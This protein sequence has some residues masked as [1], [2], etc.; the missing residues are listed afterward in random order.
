M[1]VCAAFFVCGPKND[2]DIHQHY[3]GFDELFVIRGTRYTTSHRRYTLIASPERVEA[4]AAG[5]DIAINFVVLTVL[6]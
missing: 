5:A 2:Q 6:Q 1:F 4:G 3:G